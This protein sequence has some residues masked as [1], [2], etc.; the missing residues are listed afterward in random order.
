MLSSRS[1]MTSVVV[2]KDIVPRIGMNQLE[3]LRLQLMEEINNS[4]Q[5]KV[6]TFTGLSLLTLIFLLVENN[7]TK[8][9]LLQRQAFYE[10]TVVLSGLPVL[11]LVC[12]PVHPP[13]PL[14]TRED[15][16]HS[17]AAGV[18]LVPSS[19]GR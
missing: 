8:F 10:P 4:R 13:A 2:G 16:P 9:L 18:S 14:P 17:E 19:L 6:D 15:H 7:W 5:S 1:F 11:G 12:E 3:T